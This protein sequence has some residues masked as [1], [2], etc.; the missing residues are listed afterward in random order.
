MNSKTTGYFSSALTIAG[1][2]PSGGAGIQMDLKTFAVTR[3]WGMAAV[4]ALTAQNS[5]RVSR[6]WPMDS[7]V[8]AEQIETLLQDITPGAVKT[9]MLAS[10]GI[11]RTVVAILPAEIPLIVDPVMIS[12]S[13]HRLLDEAAIQ[14]VRE[15]LIPR[16]TLVTPNIPEAEVITGLEIRDESGMEAAGWRILDLGASAVVVKGGHGS[17]LESVDLLITRDGVESLRAPRKPYQVH[18]SGCCYSAAVTGYHAS[19]YGIDQACR[20]AKALVSEA[21]RRALAGDAGIR[22]V[23]PG[24]H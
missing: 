12:T 22:M 3:V 13:G 11:I 20:K 19:G 6:V 24:M 10:A 17:G 21:I 16:A 7:A 18:G 5:Y 4:T 1:S 8:V 9:G 23:N 15:I 2:D 14:E